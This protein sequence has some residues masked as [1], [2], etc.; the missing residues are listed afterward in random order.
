MCKE[1]DHKR[2]NKK[3]RG[4]TLV[5]L[6]VVIGI[7]AIL[8]AIAIPVYNNAQTKAAQ[9]AHEAN[10]RV[11]EGAAMTAIAS[12]GVPSQKVTW[13]SNGSAAPEGMNGYKA[14]DYVKDWPEVPNGAKDKSGNAITG[15][16]T[17][18]I[19]SDGTVEVYP[20]K[21]GTAAPSTS[22]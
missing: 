2:E 14:G 7:I 13:N 4:F 5:E 16:Y 19:K 6:M 15:T 8:T 3:N 21:D 18:I 9:T 22:D 12:E 20:T 10:I 11:L 1:N 17:V